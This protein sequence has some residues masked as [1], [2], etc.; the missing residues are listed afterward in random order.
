M[1]RDKV[2][3]EQAKKI[4]D[5]L[6]KKYHISED[7][8]IRIHALIDTLKWSAI[9]LGTSV[10]FIFGKGE[11][12]SVALTRG[13]HDIWLLDVQSRNGLNR[14]SRTFDELNFAILEAIPWIP[15]LIIPHVKPEKDLL[16][17][18]DI[19]LSRYRANVKKYEKMVKEL[20]EV[21]HDINALA[22]KLFM[23]DEG[24]IKEYLSIDE[25]KFEL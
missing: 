2:F 1:K 25:D 9:N 3:A 20:P 21:R 10:N 18:K 13:D 16:R 19:M 6:E 14:D 12:S 4:A 15:Y 11:R 5:V 24:H 17:D 8:V 23:L 7:D 22:L